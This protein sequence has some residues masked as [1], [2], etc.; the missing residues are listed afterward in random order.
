M[1]SKREQKIL[2]AKR[3]MLEHERQIQRIKEALRDIERADQYKKHH[4]SWSAYK[5]KRDKVERQFAGGDHWMY[6]AYGAGDKHYATP[7]RE[8]GYGDKFKVNYL[9]VDNTE[10]GYAASQ[11][12]RGKGGEAW[13]LTT[14]TEDDLI[15]RSR[16]TGAMMSRL[17]ARNRHRRG[18]M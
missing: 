8:L 2:E 15:E 6:Y 12:R 10:G 18:R 17:H 9:G 11:Y 5:R 13:T 4:G 1:S 14:N 7:S 16:A 3:K